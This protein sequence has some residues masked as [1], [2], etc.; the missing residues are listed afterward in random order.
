MAEMPKAYEFEGTEERL[1]QWWEENGWFKPEARPDDAQPFVISIP[2]PNVTGELHQGHALVIAIEDLMIR[3]ARMQG[4]AALWVPG[5]DHAGIA[6]QLQV[7]RKLKEEG[8]S[9][10]EI[11]REAFIERTWQWKAKYGS[12]I[13]KQLRRLGASCDWDRE[14][15]TFDEGL[16]TAVREAFIRLYRLGLI[17]QG[18]YLVNWS[19]GLQTAVSDLEVEYQDEPGN[20]YYFKYPIVGGGHI[21]VATTRPE[22]ILG[23]TA[24]AVHPDDERY[25]EFVGRNAVVPILGRMIPVIADEY[26]DISFG[27]GALKVT[28]GHDPND[29]EIGQRHGLDIVNVMNKDATM[30]AEAGPY[31]GLDRFVCRQQLWADME[32]A[33]L[34]L[35]QEAYT[36][37][38]PHSQRGGEIIE[39][40]VSRQWFVDARPMAQMGL[41]AVSSGRIKIVPNRFEKVWE[42]WLENIRPWCISRQLWWGHRIP[43]WYCGDCDE[44]T[45]ER[46]DPTVCQSCGS[47]N[48]EQDPDVLDTWFSSALWPFSTLGW[49]E[50]TEDLAKFYPTDV[51]ETG[52]DILFFWVARMVMAGAMFTNDIPFHTVYLHGLVRDE[53][54]RKMSKSAGNVV[55]P[56][57]LMGLYGTDALRFTL[58]TGGTPGNDLNLSIAKVASNRN[59]ANKIWNLARF[60]VHSLERIEADYSLQ[61]AGGESYSVADKWILTRLSELVGDFDRLA[62]SYQYGEAGRQVYDFLWGDFADWYVELAKVQLGLNANS[63]ASTLSV[64]IHVMDSCLRLLHPY[65]PY[66]TEET[67][68]QLKQVFKASNFGSTLVQEWPEALI[69]ADWPSQGRTYEHESTEFERLQGLVKAIRSIRSEYGVDPARRIPALISAGEHQKS[70]ESQLPI[71]TFLARLDEA[72][73]MVSETIETPEAVI[74][75]PLGDM[76]VYLP[77]ASMVDVDKERSRLES[78]LVQLDD[79][80]ARITKLLA[81][82]FAQKAPT[83]VVDKERQKLAQIESGRNEINQRLSSL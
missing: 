18:E 21:P 79:Q 60:I 6:T 81:S 22:T 55:D 72:Q 61:N 40:M 17:Y 39:P 52:Y 82:E 11:G 31:K 83:H 53:H 47:S 66:V 44:I 2:P 32:N 46:V 56:L 67:W 41:A 51:M 12:Y 19:P 75:I 16:S 50:E 4:Y 42:N 65:I 77:L 58:L 8:T 15:F 24:V 43:V 10:E 26:V 36:V 25:A 62:D 59:F 71:L 34:T 28:P 23:D 20:L 35:K 48:I 63:A 64:L 54:G 49:P 57:D 14:R 73:T 7:E 1:Y 76:S 70:I 27:S 5:T 33:G 13:T 78:E 9:R 37:S 68:Q 3:R 45:V 69:I 30:S 80:H 74:T 38:V 29:F